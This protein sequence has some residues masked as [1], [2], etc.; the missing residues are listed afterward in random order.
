MVESEFLRFNVIVD[1]I[2]ADFVVGNVL[3]IDGNY[4]SSD[5]TSLTSTFLSFVC[6][7]K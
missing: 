6:I 7:L 3:S 4:R 2:G 5:R 1:L